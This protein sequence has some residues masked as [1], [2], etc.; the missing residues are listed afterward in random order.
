MTTIA[1]D[2]K[3]MAADSKC[4][5]GDIHFR[6]AKIF[7]LKD[8]SLLAT[9]GTSTYTAPF[10]AAML[11]G[12]KPILKDVV[13]N[14]FA[15]LHLTAD[16]LFI[17]DCTW[18]ADR[19]LSGKCA[20]GTGAMVAMSHLINGATLKVAVERACEVDNNSGLPVQVEYL[21]VR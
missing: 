1:A 5:F 7:R 9:A 2:L 21:K 6:I 10:E 16:G 12:K 20:I 3:G 14:D 13:E 18:H 4:V 19:V 17:Y 11:A 15:A 8:G